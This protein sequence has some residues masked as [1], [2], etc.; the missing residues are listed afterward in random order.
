MTIKMTEIFVK[1]TS[2]ISEKVL[3]LP[4]LEIEMAI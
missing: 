3:I 1:T 4:Q 2:I